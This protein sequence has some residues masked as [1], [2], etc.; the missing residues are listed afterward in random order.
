MCVC[1]FLLPGRT[2]IRT[3]SRRGEAF[4][5]NYSVQH[6]ADDTKKPI[7]NKFVRKTRQAICFYI[8]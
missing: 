7:H 2:G 6:K 4:L 8:I 3:I 5:R 1:L